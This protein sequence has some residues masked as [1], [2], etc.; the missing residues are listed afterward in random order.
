MN[1]ES[2]AGHRGDRRQLLQRAQRLDLHNHAQLARGLS[3]IVRRPCPSGSRDA[4]RQRRARRPADSACTRPRACAS[5]AFCTNGNISVCAPASSARLTITMSFHGSRV[6]TPAG[7]PCDRA[8]DLDDLR[9]VDRRVLHVDARGSRSR[10]SP[11]ASA[12]DGA[13]HMSQVPIGVVGDAIAC[14]KR[15]RGMSIVRL[16]SAAGRKPVVPR[17][18]GSSVVCTRHWIPPSRNDQ[19]QFYRALDAQSS[20]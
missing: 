10:R 8:Q 16:L 11:C 4:P 12:V 9:H 6:T 18:R 13:P 17:R 2:I 1:S 14:L 7:V 5:S 15:L 3:V 20:M 19:R